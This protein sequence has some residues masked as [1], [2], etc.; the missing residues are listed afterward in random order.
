MKVSKGEGPQS[1]GHSFRLARQPPGGIMKQ[2][3]RL[4]IL[5]AT[6]I[7]FYCTY[8]GFAQG[9]VGNAQLNGTVLDQ[10]GRPVV[11][12]NVRVTNTATA[13]VYTAKSHESGFYVVATVPPGT[14]DLRTSFTG[15]A[16]YSQ[17]GIVLTVGQTATVNVNLRVASLGETI[18]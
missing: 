7:F 17:T 4:R 9:G 8:L 18:V 14:C 3:S 16:N 10:S 1:S 2:R 6:A 5:L 11:G 13:T 12:A 15:F